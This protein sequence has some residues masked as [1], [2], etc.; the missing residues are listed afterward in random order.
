M[1]VISILCTRGE[2]LGWVLFG[3]TKIQS[4]PIWGETLESGI[5]H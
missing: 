3:D 2:T 5:A 4:T 1:M